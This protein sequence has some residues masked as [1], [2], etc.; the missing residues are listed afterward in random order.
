MRSVILTM[1]FIS[2]LSAT[3]PAAEPENIVYS[4]IFPG[5]GQMKEGR[6]GRGTILMGSEIAL[7]AGVVIANIQY[8]RSVEQYNNARISFETSSYIGDAQYYH[9]IMEEKW[10]SADRNDKYRKTLLGAAVGV[11]SLSMID[12][13]LGKD[14]EEI[15]IALEVA[16]EGFLITKTFSF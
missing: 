6:Y 5:W 10:D 2:L 15:P 3:A 7:L 12:M 8:D 11:W 16:D 4:A 14:P 13:L 9:G 1:I